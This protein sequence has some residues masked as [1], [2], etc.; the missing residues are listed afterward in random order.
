M[1]TA[2]YILPLG[3][4][5]ITAPAHHHAWVAMNMVFFSFR[6]AILGPA[7]FR[8]LIPFVFFGGNCSFLVDLL[9]KD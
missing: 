6:N 5:F 7:V 8:I 1:D 2:D 4:W 9:K 3:D